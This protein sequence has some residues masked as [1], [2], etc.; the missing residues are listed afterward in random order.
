[1]YLLKVKMIELEELHPLSITELEA[2]KSKE[3]EDQRV[4]FTPSRRMDSIPC[5]NKEKI[6]PKRQKS[7]VVPTAGEVDQKE[8]KVRGVNYNGPLLGYQLEI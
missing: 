3:D 7:G 2:D 4:S 1:M 6:K 5:V 8:A